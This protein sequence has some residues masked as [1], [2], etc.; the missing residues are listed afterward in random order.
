MQASVRDLRLRAAELLAAVERGESIQITYHGRPRAMLIGM[1]GEVAGSSLGRA[2]DADE[3][4]AFGLW[5][6]RMEVD[7]ESVIDQLR[8]PRPFGEAP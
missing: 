6:D 1:G 7:V 8:A 3:N 2:I 4:P 5:R